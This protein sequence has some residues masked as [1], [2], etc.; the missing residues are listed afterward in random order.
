LDTSTPQIRLV[1]SQETNTEERE[2][3][4]GSNHQEPTKIA[5][6]IGALQRYSAKGRNKHDRSADTART[7]L[8]IEE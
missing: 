1:Q 2:R 7:S 3:A 8:I 6:R 4:V 5:E